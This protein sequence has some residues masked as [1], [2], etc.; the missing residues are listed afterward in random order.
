MDRQHYMKDYRRA[1]KQRA[2]IV[3]VA[4]DNDLYAELSR[5]AKAEQ[6]TPTGLVRELVA[7]GLSGDPRVPEAVAAELRTLERLVR[8]IAN[9]INQL[10]HHANAVRRVVDVAGIFTELKRLDAAVRAYTLGRLT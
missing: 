2:R 9:N 8:S 7:T 5:R 10:A 4:L 3:K 6:R 1:Y